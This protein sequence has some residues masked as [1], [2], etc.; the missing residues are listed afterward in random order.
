MR[1]PAGRIV[2]HLTRR[3]PAGP[4]ACLVRPGRQVGLITR[5]PGSGGISRIDRRACWIVLRAQ[6]RR[7]VG[8]SAPIRATALAGRAV[9]IRSRRPASQSTVIPPG[10]PDGPI[11][12][13]GRALR[14]GQDMTSSLERANSPIW[15]R[16]RRRPAWLAGPRT[17]PGRPGLA[18]A[19]GTGKPPVRRRSHRLSA[20]GPAAIGRLPGKRRQAS[21]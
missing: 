11:G 19:A 2:R 5:I 9:L 4:I 14:I 15:S 8:L 17:T 13:S 6:A 7:P 3:P 20:G 21:N 12:R 16:S 18:R 10:Q 1:S